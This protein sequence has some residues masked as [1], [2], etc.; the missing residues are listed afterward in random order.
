MDVF[1]EYILLIVDDFREK[2]ENSYI[3]KVGIC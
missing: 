2:V 1:K 3:D